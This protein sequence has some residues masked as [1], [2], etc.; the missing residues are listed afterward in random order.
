MFDARE[1]S[2]LGRLCA[3]ALRRAYARGER[4]DGETVVLVEELSAVGRAWRASLPPISERGSAMVPQLD[5]VV[6]I[7]DT[8]LTTKEAALRLGVTPRRIVQL[9]SAG[10]LTGTKDG[11]KAW[12]LSRESVERLAATPGDRDCRARE[13]RRAERA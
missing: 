4:V 11:A 9:V 6:D 1:S 8:G 12:K 7:A 5:A 13:P 2:L 10:A 3:D